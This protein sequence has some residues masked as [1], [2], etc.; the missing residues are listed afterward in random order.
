MP[1]IINSVPFYYYSLLV[2]ITN[3]MVILLVNTN[4][5]K[6]RTKNLIRNVR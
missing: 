1:I 4:K 3:Y 5:Y 2:C 6:I